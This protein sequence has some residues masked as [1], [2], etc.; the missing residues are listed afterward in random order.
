MVDVLT[1][2]LS[3][4]ISVDFWRPRADFH[5]KIS[6]SVPVERS[7]VEGVSQVDTELQLGHAFEVPSSHSGTAAFMWGFRKNHIA[8]AST[9][10]DENSTLDVGC[11][12]LSMFHPAISKQSTN[13]MHGWD[14]TTIDSKQGCWNICGCNFFVL[15]P[16]W[17]PLCRKLCVACW[18]VHRIHFFKN[19]IFH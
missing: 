1:A 5:E 9:L 12:F 19:R 6:S 11:D 10:P 17:L 18:R 4:L 8:Y 15:N 14:L 3:W 7:I 16:G 13:L 2:S